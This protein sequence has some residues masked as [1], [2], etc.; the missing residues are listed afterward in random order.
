M[1]R[2]FLR[3]LLLATVLVFLIILF[4]A[5]S[6]FAKR[7]RIE[8]PE[9]VVVSN[10]TVLL[11]DIGDFDQSPEENELVSRL[12]EVVVLSTATASF[13]RKVT[14]GQ[15]EVRLRLA[16]I[17]PA[18]VEFVGAKEIQLVYSSESNEWTTPTITMKESV[19]TTPSNSK[20]TTVAVVVAIS[21]IARGELL[22]QDNIVLEYR[23]VRGVST[24]MRL[25]DFLGKQARQTILSGT[26]LNDLMVEIPPV[27]M[28]GA[29]VTIIAEVGGISVR[30]AG[31]ARANG[32]KG[33]MI[34]VENSSSGNIIYAEV[35]DSETVRVSVRGDD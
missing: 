35:I 1:L 27:V 3:K 14:V 22:T 5:E 33:E 23:D 13:P 9:Q 2:L 20:Q 25:E 34:P 28:R 8:L 31:I 26:A 15:I 7:I 16:K 11:K 6:G 21:N 30:T 4:P 18:L 29:R 12:E 24:D 17:D 10:T 19:P 32:G